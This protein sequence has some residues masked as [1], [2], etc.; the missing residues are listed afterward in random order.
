M[1]RRRPACYR[2]YYS[3]THAL[4]NINMEEGNKTKKT[5]FVGGIG[6]DVN[7]EIILEAFSTFGAPSPK[8]C[9]LRR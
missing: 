7:E 5:I 1:C 2:I 9:A 8:P 4:T 3:T 6:E